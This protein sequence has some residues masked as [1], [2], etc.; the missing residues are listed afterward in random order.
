[1][2]GS[3]T[4]ADGACA[5]GLTRQRV[6]GYCGLAA[7]LFIGEAGIAGFDALGLADLL[8]GGELIPAVGG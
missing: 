5:S 7:C 6:T 8:F 3:E 4:L 1:M 2:R